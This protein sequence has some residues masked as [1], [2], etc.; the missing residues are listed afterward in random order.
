MLCL[1]NI[2][3]AKMKSAYAHNLKRKHSQINLSAFPKQADTWYSLI[4][5]DTYTKEE[6]EKIIDELIAEC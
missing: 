3:L 6:F 2:L 5:D 1:R 4:I